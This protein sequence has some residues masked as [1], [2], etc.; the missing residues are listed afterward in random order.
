MTL[1]RD[2]AELQE[3]TLSYL[4]EQG[5][6]THTLSSVRTE[7][8]SRFTKTM[9]KQFLTILILYNILLYSLLSKIIVDRLSWWTL[10]R[11]L[12]ST[13]MVKIITGTEAIAIDEALKF[14]LKELKDCGYEPEDLEEIKEA[15]TILKGLKEKSIEEVLG[16]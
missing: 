7:T 2:Q 12:K 3:K 4:K 9:S 8:E 1:Y 5:N 14:A 6:F 16:V 13:L 10:R 11:S 15:R